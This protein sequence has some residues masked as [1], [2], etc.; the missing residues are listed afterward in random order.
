M[1][2]PRVYDVTTP[3]NQR[4]NSN[5]KMVINITKL[6]SDPTCV[7]QEACHALRT[8]IVEFRSEFGVFL[9][10]ATEKYFHAVVNNWNPRSYSLQIV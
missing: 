4:I 8:E 7:F 2:P 5:T 6:L 9:R 10:E 3:S 1:N